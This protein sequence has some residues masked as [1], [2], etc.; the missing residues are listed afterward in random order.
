MGRHKQGGRPHLGLTL[1][2][3]PQSTLMATDT[4]SAED[5]QALYFSRSDTGQ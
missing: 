1:T 2:H 4:F 5:Q 3:H